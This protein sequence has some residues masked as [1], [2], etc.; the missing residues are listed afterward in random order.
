MD[1]IAGWVAPIATIIAAMMTAANLGPRIT[2]WGFV[3]FTAGSVAW[4]VVGF[5]SGQRNL[6]AANLFLTLVNL[7]GV[8]RWLGREARL[9]DGARAAERDSGSAPTPELVEIGSIEGRPILDE[10]GNKVAEAAGAMAEAASGRIAYILIRRGGLAGVGDSF[11][12]LGWD[13]LTPRDK[14][15]R[16][17]LSDEEVA[18]LPEV[19]PASWPASAA[20]AS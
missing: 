13:M 12:A 6:I 10:K 11:H 2:G 4:S 17:C 1:D 7:V 3:V 9:E 19:D 14:A 20:A 5:A 16:T 8:W 15:F 18:A